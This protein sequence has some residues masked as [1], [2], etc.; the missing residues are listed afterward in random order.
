MLLEVG[1]QSLQSRRVQVR[2]PWDI[3]LACNVI[4]RL[5]Y[6]DEPLLALVNV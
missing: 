6:A 3:A 1:S 2:Q 5:A 4:L